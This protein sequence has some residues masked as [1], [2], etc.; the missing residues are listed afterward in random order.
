MENVLTLKIVHVIIWRR[1]SVL[2][3]G[4]PNPDNKNLF[5]FGHQKFF[6]AA[7]RDKW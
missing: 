5:I 3:S 4:W 7:A 1:N 2:F 6:G